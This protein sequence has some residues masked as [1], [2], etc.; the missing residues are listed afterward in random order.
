M[1]IIFVLNVGTQMNK[2]IDIREHTVIVSFD[3]GCEVTSDEIPLGEN[4]DGENIS[5]IVY[6][7]HNKKV[8]SMKIKNI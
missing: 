2:D 5:L 1:V 6:R 8:V 7:N 4:I 3:K